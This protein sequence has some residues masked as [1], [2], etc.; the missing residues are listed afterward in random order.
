MSN[1]L[2]GMAQDTISLYMFIIYLYIHNNKKLNFY[3]GINET[4]NTQE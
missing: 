1:Y 2:I 3:N 4:T